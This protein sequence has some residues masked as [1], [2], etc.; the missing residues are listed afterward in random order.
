MAPGEFIQNI[1]V[2]VVGLLIG[3]PVGAWLAA[4]S[5]RR[6]LNKVGP[7]LIRLI[8][9]L[10]E[11]GNLSPEAARACVVCTARVLSHEIEKQKDGLGIPKRR[12]E[13]CTVCM[14]EY[15]T[16][17]PKGGSPECA[18]CGLHNNVWNIIDQTVR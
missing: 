7:P 10:R 9:Q 18:G 14:L 8:K 13:K 15:K 3:I 12:D 17:S 6:R 5:A 11:D 1:A 16:I 4:T 2:E